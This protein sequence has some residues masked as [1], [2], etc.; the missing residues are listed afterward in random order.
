MIEV[1]LG[2]ASGKFPS[3]ARDPQ[4]LVVTYHDEATG[5]VVL[6]QLDL[7]GQRRVPDFPFAAHGA[8]D[9]YPT[10]YVDSRQHTWLV[11]R[12]NADLCGHLH[13]L[14]GNQFVNLGVVHGTMP[15]AFGQDH[16]AWLS[17]GVWHVTERDLLTGKERPYPERA[18]GTGLSHLTPTDLWTIDELRTTVPG[19]V[20]PQRAG[21]CAVGEADGPD[22]RPCNIARLDDG[23][24]AILWPGKVSFTPRITTAGGRYY[25]VTW[26]AP[27]GVRLM[28]LEDSDFVRAGAPVPTPVPVP[29]PPGPKPDPKPEPL[30]TVQIPDHFLAL[31]AVSDAHPELL[32]ENSRASMTELLW[33]V[34]AALN[35]V[36]PN[37]GLLSKSPG[38]NHTEI[39]GLLV[40]V[41]ALAYGTSDE[42][43]DIFGSAYDGPGKGSLTWHVDERRPSNKWVTPPPFPGTPVPVPVPTPTP[44][45]VPAPVP[46]PPAVD[47][48]LR[49]AVIELGRVMQDL[50]AGQAVLA[51]AVNDLRKRVEELSKHDDEV[52]VQQADKVIAAI[53]L[54][55]RNTRA[56]LY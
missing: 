55:I 11:Y 41:D 29:P 27:W 40:A 37:W 49:D 38:E 51:A 19:M 54:A 43:V 28:I 9:A 10:V 39:G 18:A 30:P 46:Q 42:I 45:P 23:R 31:K 16:I 1:A 7:A 26:G 47:Q 24:Q 3:I 13:D 50:N 32:A 48:V 12:D 34:A 5:G 35:A 17:S 36:D 33:R 21:S 53:P 44:T 2:P 6:Q 20:N 56:R 4:G 14:T 25:V 8:P 52:A 15:F 22:G